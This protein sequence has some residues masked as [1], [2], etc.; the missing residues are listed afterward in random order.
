MS[1]YSCTVCSLKHCGQAMQSVAAPVWI[2]PVISEMC[3]L[4]AAAGLPVPSSH[5][6]FQTPATSVSSSWHATNAH[7][8]TAEACAAKV[9]GAPLTSSLSSRPES[10]LEPASPAAESVAG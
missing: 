3:S 8:S 1:C 5:T 10:C 6:S 2:M 4:V 9:S 7:G